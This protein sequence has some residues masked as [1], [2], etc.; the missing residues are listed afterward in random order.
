MV[1]LLFCRRLE[2]SCVSASVRQISP[3][4]ST[5]ILFS[6]PSSPKWGVRTSVRRSRSSNR[7]PEPHCR[8]SSERIKLTNSRFLS[9][10]FLRVWRATDGDVHWTR[11]C[12]PIFSQRKKEK[13]YLFSPNELWI[14]SAAR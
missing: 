8:K 7:K 13:T 5:Q 2:E 6:V 14:L 4:G 11:Q 9:T 3:G 10:P 1:M 12:T